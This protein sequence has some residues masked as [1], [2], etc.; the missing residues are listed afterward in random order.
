M[1]RIF[2]RIITFHI[3]GEIYDKETTPESIIRN[4]NWNTKSDTNKI[5]IVGNHKDN[6]GAITKMIH[7]PKIHPWHKK[8]TELFLI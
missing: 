5:H 4:Y 7:L 3:Q 1:P 2:N 6:R 8:D